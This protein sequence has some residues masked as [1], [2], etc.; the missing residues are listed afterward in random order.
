MLSCMKLENSLEKT[1]L[2]SK[3][4]WF[5]TRKYSRNKTNTISGITGCVLSTVNII[6]KKRFLSIVAI[7]L[8]CSNLKVIIL[9]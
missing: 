5:R 3:H 1:Y 6:L 9:C 4:K 2:E 8:K 7:T